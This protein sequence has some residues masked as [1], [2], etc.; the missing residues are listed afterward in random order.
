MDAECFGSCLPIVGLSMVVRARCI[1]DPACVWSWAS[2]PALRALQTEFGANLSWTFV[3]GGLAREL[4][5]RGLAEPWMAAAAKSGM[6]TD[7]RVWH[8]GPM[9]STYPACMAVIAAAEQA[10]DGGYRYLRALREAIT[11]F[12][13]KLDNSEALIGEAR[14]AGLDVER[15]RIDLSSNAVVEALGAHLEE[16]RD[17]P[18]EADTAGDV[19][20][21]RPADRERVVFPT[22]RFEDESGRVRWLFGHQSP[23]ELREAAVA[24][25]ARPSGEPRPSVAEALRRFGRMAVPEVAA[26]CALA[27]L[28]AEADLIALALEWRARPVPVLAGRLWEAA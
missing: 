8:E 3:M 28:K 21:S 16:A 26:V 12:G 4:P 27:P 2:E 14:D 20:C 6:P 5:P 25:G 23:E 17:V 24:A 13:R 9:K 15:F 1:T 11:C 19:T 7:P 22:W 10:T 18:A